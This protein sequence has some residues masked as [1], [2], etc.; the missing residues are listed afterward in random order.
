M[1]QS[2]VQMGMPV[3]QLLVALILPS[4]A[5]PCSPATIEPVCAIQHSAAKSLCEV[6]GGAETAVFQMRREWLP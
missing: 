2:V 6:V 1:E 4:S 5:L 3:L